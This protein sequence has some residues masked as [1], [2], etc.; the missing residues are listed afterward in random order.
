MTT[1]R[2]ELGAISS[3]SYYSEK[4]PGHSKPDVKKEMILDLK[5]MYEQNQQRESLDDI[6]LPKSERGSYNI[7]TKVRKSPTSSTKA[8]QNTANM[9]SQ[10]V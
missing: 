2:S 6:V 5:R 10:Q 4:N 1:G 8:Q 7:F 3:A 9:F